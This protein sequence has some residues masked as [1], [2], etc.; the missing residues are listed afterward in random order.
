MSTDP[1]RLIQEDAQARITADAW[2]TPI[3]TILQRVG[4][5]EKDIARRLTVLNEKGTKCGACILVM[6]PGGGVPDQ[7][8]GPRLQLTLSFIALEHPTINAGGTG[9]GKSAEEIAI[10]LLQLFNHASL[11]R[12]DCFQAGPDALVPNDSF[13]GLVGYQVNLQMPLQLAKTEMVVT[14]KISATATAAPATVTIS[15]ATDGASIWYTTDGSYPSAQNANALLYA[16]PFSV[17]SAKLI[18]AAAEKTGLQ[19]SNVAQL[20]IAAAVG[21]VPS[22]FSPGFSPGFG[23]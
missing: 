18:R 14:P 8:P 17:N 1:L 20:Q 9:T 21:E 23:S 10:K 7:T 19:Q 5:S 22:A 13:D 3:A 4:V 16:T 2:F 6:M 12:G 11:G 15:C